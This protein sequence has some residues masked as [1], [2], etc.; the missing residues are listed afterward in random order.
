MIFFLLINVELSTIVDISTCMDRKNS[1]L[2]LSE[3]EKRLISFSTE[4]SIKKTFYNLG[5]RVSLI[6]AYTVPIPS[7]VFEPR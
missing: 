5:P 4:L 7:E 3:H 2:G 1:I 6:W